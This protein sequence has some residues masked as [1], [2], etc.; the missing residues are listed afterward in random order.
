M[1]SL[2]IRLICVPQT[3][4]DRD[5]HAV[6]RSFTDANGL[7]NVSCLKGFWPDG[8]YTAATEEA[9]L[10]DMRVAHALGFNTLRKHIKVE[11]DH[12]YHAADKL[13]MLIWQDMPSMYWVGLYCY[14]RWPLSL[15]C[16]VIW[17]CNCIVLAVKISNWRPLYGAAFRSAC[18]KGLQLV[19]CIMMAAMS[20]RRTHTLA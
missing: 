14:A 9:L 16:Q 8:I 17:C 3:L 20:R 4:S 15:L 10:Y 6:Y 12:Y 7:L 19:T 5:L 13:G 11:P 18:R 2:A 1:F